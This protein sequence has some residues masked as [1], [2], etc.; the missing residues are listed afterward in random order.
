MKVDIKMTDV[1]E[2]Q[3]SVDMTKAEVLSAKETADLFEV[4]MTVIPHIHESWVLSTALRFYMFDKNLIDEYKIPTKHGKTVY[5]Y[6]ASTFRLK[7]IAMGYN[8]FI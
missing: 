5:D 4:V 2:L 3:K 6:Y 1:K 7:M 8:E